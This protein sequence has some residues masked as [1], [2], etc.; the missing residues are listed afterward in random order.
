MRR[1]TFHVASKSGPTNIVQL[2]LGHC[3]DVNARDK[4]CL[5]PLHLAAEVGTLEVVNLLLE[6]GANVE[7]KDDVDRTAFQDASA[8]GHE[9][10]TLLSE[11]GSNTGTP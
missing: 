10:V 8:E 6:R 2:L 3:V 5:T 1:T 4:N 11:H 9:V 7:A